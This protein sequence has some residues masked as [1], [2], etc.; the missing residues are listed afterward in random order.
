MVFLLNLLLP[1]QLNAHWFGLMLTKNV[2]FDAF[3]CVF[4]SHLQM[5]MQ[6]AVILDTSQQEIAN[7]SFIIF[8]WAVFQR[9]SCV[10]RT[11]LKW[12]D[13]NTTLIIKSCMFD[14][15]LYKSDV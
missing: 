2:D 12:P 7:V 14:V 3:I 1:L 5:I 8:I 9:Y 15:Y 11:R 13:G 4:C 6:A 10:Q